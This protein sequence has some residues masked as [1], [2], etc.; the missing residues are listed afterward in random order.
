LV[1]EEPLRRRGDFPGHR[2]HRDDL[3][4]GIAHGGQGQRY[5]DASAVLALSSRDDVIDAFPQH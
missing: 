4:L 1:R 2:R 3:A 5:V